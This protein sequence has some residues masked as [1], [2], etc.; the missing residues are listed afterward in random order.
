MTDTLC[1]ATVLIPVA[2]TR[3]KDGAYIASSPLMPN[4]V[5]VWEDFDQL[6]KERVPQAVAEMTRAAI[7]SAEARLTS[8]TVQPS[9]PV[10]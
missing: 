3:G 5:V 10:R 1:T 9:P 8:P 7:A 6:L 2:I 4:L